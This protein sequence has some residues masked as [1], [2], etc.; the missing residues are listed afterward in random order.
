MALEGL[1]TPREPLGPIDQANIRTD[2]DSGR[3]IYDSV[4][5][6][7]EALGRVPVLLLGRKGSGKSAI[8]AEYRLKVFHREDRGASLDSPPDVREP[9]LISIGSWDHF[10]Q[11]T[12]HVANQFRTENPAFDAEIV[13]S[14][15]LSRLWQVAIW[16]EIIKYFYNFCHHRESRPYLAP[17]EK[18]IVADGS[19][20]GS[21]EKAASDLFENAKAAALNYARLRMSRI[22]FLI[23]SMERYPVRNV[24]FSEVLS[25]LLHAINTVHYESDLIHITFCLPE[26]IEAHLMSASANIMKDYSAAYRIRWKPIDLLKVVAHR[27]R[28][29]IEMRDREF[30]K[31]VRHIN[32]ESREGIHGFFSALLPTSIKNA[33]GEPEDPLAYIIRHTQLLPRH[34]IA[35]FNGIVARSYER[36][37]QVR[38]IDEESIR[39][40]I[41]D[42]EKLIAQQVL[43]PY[44]K[45]Y[46]EL[47]S[48]CEDVLPDLAPVCSYS[49]LRKIER[50]FARRVEDDI[51]NVW[52][53]LFAMGVI[54]KVVADEP[55]G[56]DRLLARYCLG[57]FHYNV[58]GSFGLSA[59]AEYCFHPVFSRHFGIARRNGGDKRAVYPAN[60]EMITL[61]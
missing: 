1:L 29:F 56:C 33:M 12:R 46:P 15:Y 31:K 5:P 48:V 11:L 10:H 26:E 59:E 17:I 55:S 27:L 23:D 58:D 53:T 25:G 54:G 36:T 24:V 37:K 32:L 50:R 42:A 2:Q 45:I 57:Q 8:L 47:I 16:D 3:I 4:T 60:I 20:T 13:P 35:I 34:A 30:Y 21:P 41:A 14:E 61:G 49:D 22:V 19:Y 28:L 43:V 38:A 9:F 51:H 44:Y 18:Y 7:N 39:E 40:G 52:R 6:F